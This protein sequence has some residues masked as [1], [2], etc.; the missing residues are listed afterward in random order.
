MLFTDLYMF[1]K[2]HSIGI[3][4]AENY[5]QKYSQGNIIYTIMSSDLSFLIQNE[6]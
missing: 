4:E 1:V 5:I 6:N 3:I 2:L